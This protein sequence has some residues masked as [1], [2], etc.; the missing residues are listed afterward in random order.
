MECSYNWIL[1]ND[2]E[3]QIFTS[4]WVDVTVKR[5]TEKGLG[6]SSVGQEDAQCPHC[7]VLQAGLHTRTFWSRLFRA[8][9]GRLLTVFRVE[10]VL[11]TEEQ[12]WSSSSHLDRQSFCGHFKSAY[13]TSRHDIDLLFHPN[14]GSICLRAS[15]KT[16]RVT[17]S[18]FS[19][20]VSGWL[21]LVSKGCVMLFLL[22]VLFILHF[23]QWWEIP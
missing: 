11:I 16:W 19:L 1:N 6:S 12:G 3:I 20:C 8:S 13:N 18:F 15:T 2:D 23:K 17:G 4:T 7:A 5:W 9:C 14:S 10:I 22:K 21:V